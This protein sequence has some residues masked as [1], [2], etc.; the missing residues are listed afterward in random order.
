MPIPRI[1]KPQPCPLE[2][3]EA[4]SVRLLVNPTG[5]ELS[6]WQLGTL[7]LPGCTDCEALNAPTVA[8]GK[9]AQPA[10]APAEWQYCPTCATLRSRKARACVA[11]YGPTLLGRP[12]TTE[13]EALAILDDDDIPTEVFVWLLL[14][15]EQVVNARM[16]Q[17]RPNSPGSATTRST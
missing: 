4:L 17:L 15:P 14:L 12:C 5:R 8:R 10:E 13:A 9:K 1:Y 2:G 6:D 3:Y 11:L 7:G 16:E